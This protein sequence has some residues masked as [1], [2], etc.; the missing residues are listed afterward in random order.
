MTIFLINLCGTKIYAVVADDVA[1]QVED[2]T[3]IENS[4]Y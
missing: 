3:Y 4:E 2:F 1:D